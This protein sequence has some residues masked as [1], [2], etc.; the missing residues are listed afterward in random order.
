MSDRE[1]VQLA[2][3]IADAYVAELRALGLPTYPGWDRLSPE[4]KI[5]AL[6]SVFGGGTIPGAVQAATF[7]LTIVHANASLQYLSDRAK[8]ALGFVAKLDPSRWF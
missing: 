8:S 5:I 1:N 6:A 7:V 3:G 2:A 4:R